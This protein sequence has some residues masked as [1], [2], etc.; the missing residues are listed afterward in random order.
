MIN[1]LCQDYLR[2]LNNGNLEDVLSLFFPD[3]VVVSPLYGEME[4]M[5]FYADLFKDTNLSETSLLNVLS[6]NTNET[7][8][9]LHFHYKWTLKNGK[10]VE[11]EC[12][13]VLELSDDKER[14]RK[15][16]II[17]DTA[18]IR[19]DVMESRD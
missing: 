1:Q 11:F 3:A 4:V 15:L 13:D 6:S 8:A 2:A 16:K 14:F 7:V 12:V 19:G 10:I 5:K 9:A 17:Y 18:P